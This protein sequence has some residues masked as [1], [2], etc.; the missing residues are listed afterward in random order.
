MEEMIWLHTYI[1]QKSELDSQI[2]GNLKST[3]RYGNVVI[4]KETLNLT[5]NVSN[6]IGINIPTNT[7]TN[8]RKKNSN[9]VVKLDRLTPTPLPHCQQQY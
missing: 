9:Y 6:T 8:F 5:T 2:N 4:S 3:K 1:Q 7:T